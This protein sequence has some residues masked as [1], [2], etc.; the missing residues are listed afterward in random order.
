MGHL[1]MSNDGSRFQ[2]SHDTTNLLVSQTM[3][4]LNGKAVRFTMR[5]NQA[6]HAKQSD[7]DNASHNNNNNSQGNGSNNSNDRENKSDVV[8]WPDS[9][10]DDYR[11]RPI[12][13]NDMCM[14]EFVAKYQKIFKKFKSMD[15]RK[16]SDEA[17]VD[18]L[19]NEYPFMEEHPGREFSQFQSTIT[20]VLH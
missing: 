7:E 13:L 1:I 14:Y 10:V 3:D 15:K 18:L 11:F 17:D 5:R 4:V 20:L 8:M 9:T 2:Y 19:H 16:K 12:E 6:P